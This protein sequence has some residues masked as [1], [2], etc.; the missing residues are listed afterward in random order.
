MAAI[1][2]NMGG[3][4]A[5]SFWAKNA[6]GSRSFVTSTGVPGTPWGFT[7]MIDASQVHETANRLRVSMI[8]AG[9]LVGI[10]LAVVV[11]L[12]VYRSLKPLSVVGETIRGIASGNADLTKRLAL[13]SANNNEIGG[14]VSGF[15]QFTEKLQEII[16]E[17]KHSK[18]ELITS[19]QSMDEATVE[20][21]S[22]ITEISANIAS[23]GNSIHSQS[24][25]VTQ[26]AGAVNE[27]AS[28]IESLNQMIEGQSESVSQAASAVE[29]MIGNINSVGASVGK[30][31][32]AF[33]RLESKA[34]NGVQ[35]QAD[36]NKRLGEMQEESKTLQEANTVI[37]SIASQTNLLA[38]NAAIEAAHAGEA[39]RGFAVV[40]DEIRKLS[41]TSTAQSKRIGEQLKKIATSI[42]GIV[43]ASGQT[44]KAFTDISGGIEET[45][46]LV[47][48][49]RAAM[50]E[51][52]EGSRQITAA[53]NSMSNSTSEVRAASLEMSEGNKAILAEIQNLQ[54]TTMSIRQGMDEMGA[55]TQKIN[56]TGATLGAIA[57]EVKRSIS[58]IGSQVDLFKV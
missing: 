12:I 44:G 33:Q 41:E 1:Q 6:R 35:K 4:A 49:I 14:V 25:S 20:T 2:R 3:T 37:S 52:S 57:E 27:I 42:S 40:A 10:I 53:L 39:G 45:D 5:V 46:V 26:T 38:M 30:L 19:G 18:D 31:A 55:G 13:S 22:A 54:D 23:M 15:N 24:N 8:V 21:T 34:E 28:N 11:G 51:Q 43:Q 7:F 58:Q 56:E 9:T 48:Q 50:Q 47:R 16:R 17:I 32:D 29:Q 36:V